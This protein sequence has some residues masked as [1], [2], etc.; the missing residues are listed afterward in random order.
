MAVGC[1]VHCVAVPVILAAAP[2]GRGLG[3]GGH[4]W[5]L[6]DWGWVAGPWFH[7]LMAVA[8][9]GLIAPTLVR[10]I[11]RG[12][13]TSIGWLAG[14][15]ASLLLVSAFVVPDPC[16]D[17]EA[18]MVG[19]A[20]SPAATLFEPSTCRRALGDSGFRRLMSIQPLLTPL[21]GVLLAAAHLVNLDRCRR[22]AQRRREEPSRPVRSSPPLAMEVGRSAS[23]ERGE[24]DSA[25]TFGRGHGAHGLVSHGFAV[26]APASS[27]AGPS[28]ADPP[29]SGPGSRGMS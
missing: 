17:P 7:Q 5:G 28:T 14:T 8:C 20:V 29:S 13:A 26:P 11:R 23:G 18:S 1:A 21:G 9:C 3:S 22:P 27:E 2:L 6:H 24:A 4:G 16:C 19:G 15:G 25:G 12:S 10:S